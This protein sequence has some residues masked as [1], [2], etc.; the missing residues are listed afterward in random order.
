MQSNS[1]GICI[2]FCTSAGCILREFLQ[3]DGSNTLSHDATAAEANF[4]CFGCS[5][6]APPRV[7]FG[8]WARPHPGFTRKIDWKITNFAKIAYRT[9][10]TVERGTFPIAARY[11]IFASFYVSHLSTWLIAM[12]DSRLSRTVSE[13][14]LPRSSRSFHETTPYWR[15]KSDMEGEMEEDGEKLASTSAGTSSSPYRTIEWRWGKESRML[16]TLTRETRKNKN[17]LFKA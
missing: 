10:D 12:F 2:V 9:M 7:I 17:W 14:P 15:T 3:F 6:D 16:R 11:Y 1:N 4:G 5:Q 8:S 13:V